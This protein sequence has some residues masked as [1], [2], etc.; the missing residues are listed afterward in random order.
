CCVAA[1]FLSALGAR[2]RPRRRLRSAFEPYSSSLRRTARNL[3]SWVTSSTK[4]HSA[5]SSELCFRLQERE[6]LLSKHQPATSAEKLCC[7]WLPPSSRKH[8]ALEP[9]QLNSNEPGRARMVSQ[10]A[11]NFVLGIATR[12]AEPA[13]S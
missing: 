11:T 10:S 8:R 3:S 12:P 9:F 13:T 6:K 4:V 7:K 1:A 2:W 5:S